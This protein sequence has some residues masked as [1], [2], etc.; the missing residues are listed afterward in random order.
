LISSKADWILSK[1]QFT[2][3]ETVDLSGAITIFLEVSLVSNLVLKIEPFP[4]NSLYL[5]PDGNRKNP[6]LRASKDG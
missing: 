6:N 1:L 2:F 5:S 4:I 3:M